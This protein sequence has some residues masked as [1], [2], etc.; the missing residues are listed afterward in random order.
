PVDNRAPQY[1]GFRA[2]AI[3]SPSTL[4]LRKLRSNSSNAFSPYSPYASAVKL[5]PEI[6]VTRSTSSSRRTL[7]PEAFTTSM[8]RN[9]SSTPYA[10]A[11]AR[12][13]PPEKARMTK[14]SEL[15]RRASISSNGY[16]AVASYRVRRGL[17]ARVAQPAGNATDMTRSKRHA[18][19]G[20]RGVAGESGWML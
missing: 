4:R 18:S 17:M 7:R 13:P 9:A 10:K 19:D 14:F 11:A 16:G 2:R 8:R 15:P 5:P 3:N 12:V 1:L 20:V 6:P